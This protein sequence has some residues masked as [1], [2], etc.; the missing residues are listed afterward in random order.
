MTPQEIQ[1]N[2]I[3]SF[4]FTEQRKRR[5][6]NQLVLLNNL[7]KGDQNIASTLLI[8]LLNRTV[9]ALYDDKLQVKFL[10][11][12]GITQDQINAYNILAESDYQEMGKKKMDYDWVWD[13]G[14]FGAGY[15]ETYRFDKK[16]KIMSPTTINPLMMGYD[17]YFENV[18]DWRY[19]WKWVLKDKWTIE[20]Y[21]KAGKITGITRAE[22]LPG[23]V[24][25]YLWEYKQ[26]RDWATKAVEP[27][28]IPAGNDV[29]QILE[30][31]GH[32]AKGERCAFWTDKYFSKI[33]MEEPLNLKNLVLENGD[34]SSKW[35]IVKKEF[36][37]IPH[38]SVPI[39]IADVLDDKHRAES[40]LLNLAFIAAKDAA[41]PLYVYNPEQVQD[42]AQFFS[43]QINQHIPI[44]GD[45]ATAVAPLNVKDPLPPGLINFMTALR[46]QA[47]EPLG[48]GV[49]MQPQTTVSNETATKAAI[50]QQMND[51]AQSLASK[52]MQFGE[53][54][55]WV[56]WFHHY[57]NN[58]DSLKTKM[59]NIVGVRGINTYE[60]DLQDF[61]TDYPPGV[62]VYSA[63]EAEYKNLVKRRDFMQ[64][65]PTL[66]Q[67]MDPDG[68]K[69]F[70]KHV[71]MPLMLEDPSLI[72]VMYPKTPE[73]MKAEEQNEMLKSNEMPPVLD[74]D[75][76][77]THLYIHRMVQPKT[78]ATWFHIAEHEEA[79]AKQQQQAMMQQMASPEGSTGQPT[80]SNMG[81]ERKSPLGAA[82]PLKQEA[83]TTLTSKNKN[84]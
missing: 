24:D 58:A 55:F 82:S 46:Q 13:S 69:N 26:R 79:L 14:F 37:R 60:I 80:T 57:K 54:E 50:D 63:K 12:Q 45:P 65:Y 33:L 76:H 44:E 17:P 52:I 5:Q 25:P 64:L 4:Q 71:F 35:P 3:E 8:T 68:F 21:I 30:Y 81:A 40:V 75:D 38:S 51:M 11:S 16:R 72:D 39:S 78:N 67:T 62:F 29:Y 15:A 7:N 56:D 34:I 61:K 18:Q 43:R 48:T 6:S 23:G 47:N 27:A 9:S 53:E 73:E 22:E 74:T 77:M 42:V 20:R 31:Y 66:A 1:T 83:K 59:A 19:Y 84:K 32:N 2:F 10:P 41:N 28:P 70:N 49:S 36:F